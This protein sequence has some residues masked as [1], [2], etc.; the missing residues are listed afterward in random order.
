MTKQFKI[1]ELDFVRAG[2]DFIPA[3]WSAHIAGTE[4]QKNEKYTFER[5]D[6]TTFDV[7]AISES[8]MEGKKVWLVVEDDL[9]MMMFF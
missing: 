5:D 7:W 3:G 6:G 4:F 2:T 8:I 9:A 1:S